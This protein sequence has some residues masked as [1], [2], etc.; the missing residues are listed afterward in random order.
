MDV[1]QRA[2]FKTAHYAFGTGLGAL[3]GVFAGIVSAILLASFQGSTTYVYFFIAV[4]ILTV[5]GMLTLL[6][7]PLDEQ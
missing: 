5:P 3:C 7:I 6:F 1:A 2:N 4:C